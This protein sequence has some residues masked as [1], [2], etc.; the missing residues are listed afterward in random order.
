MRAFTPWPGAYTTLRGRICHVVAEPVSNEMTEA[1]SG[2]SSAQEAAAPGT[3]SVAPAGLLVS[4]GGA[5]QLRVLS[6]KQEG[7]KSIDAV[8]FAHG[9]RLTEGERFGDR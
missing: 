8:E 6:V 9:A 1:G 7:G 2:G 5:T 3:L 4:C